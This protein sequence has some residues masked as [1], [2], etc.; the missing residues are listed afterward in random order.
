MMPLS[1]I[2]SSAHR[3]SLLRGL[4]ATLLLVL[5]A[6][7]LWQPR[8]S[9]TDRGVPLPPPNMNSTTPANAGPQ[10][11]VLAGG[12]FWGM[13][14]VFQHVK[15]VI[16]VVSGYS[17]G[18]KSTADYG[19]VSSGR[20]GHAES[21]RITFDPQ[22]ISY[23]EILRIYFSVAHNPT[24]LDRQGP[25]TGR[26][27]RSDIFYA[28]DAQKKEALAYITQLNDAKVFQRP[29]V[30]RVDPLTGFYP[31]ESYHQ[32]FAYRHPDNPYIVYNDLPKVKNLQRLF[33][34]V[35]RTS[36]VNVAAR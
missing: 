22:K 11:A 14:A 17:G 2:L 19:T 27:Y 23:A 28:N 4:G 5:L 18:Q 24:E 29:I 13:E 1:R 15:G 6:G 10:T 30:T 32:N 21:V 20:T 16:D 3:Y 34:G 35:Y 25:D 12:C 36:P 31:A 33:P 26:Q 8:A 7:L 9:A